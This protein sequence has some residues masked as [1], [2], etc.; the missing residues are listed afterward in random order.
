M[1]RYAII[2]QAAAILQTVKKHQLDR[3][4]TNK[5]TGTLALLRRAL[6]VP[7]DPW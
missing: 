7:F 3:G 6:Y 1:L 5:H 4:A 2:M